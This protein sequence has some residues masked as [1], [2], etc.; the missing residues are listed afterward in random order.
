MQPVLNP[1]FQIGLDV[2]DKPCLIIGGGDEATEKAGRLL[3]AGAA[4]TLVSPDA[5]SSLAA[6]VA[7]GRLTHEARRFQADDLGADT[8]LVLNTV[9][10]DPDL[11][12]Q[13]F[14]LAA[15]HK[16]LI[17]SFDQPAFSNFGMVA[18]VAPGH[19][20]LGISTSNASPALSGRLRRELE[21]LFDDE[22]SAYLAALATVRADLKE[23]LPDRSRRFALLKALVADF[24]IDGRLAYPPDWRRRIDAVSAC[25]LQGCGSSDRCADCPLPAPA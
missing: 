19:L 23:R 3:A 7:D 22:F 6:W 9:R 13:V 10:S 18:L 11:T 20:R 12:R 15:R 21:K 1:Y 8:F 24:R 14:D 17:N 16:A 4:V 2:L 25:D 5:T